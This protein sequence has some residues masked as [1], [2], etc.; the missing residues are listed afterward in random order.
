MTRDRLASGKTIFDP[1]TYGLIVRKRRKREKRKQ[2]FLQRFGI[3][4]QLIHDTEYGRGR[5]VPL[6]RFVVMNI[7][8]F[9]EPFPPEVVK[10][11]MPIPACVKIGGGDKWQLTELL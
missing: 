7:A 6:E 8:L 3:S 4:K 1:K 5:T 2:Y 10:A 9:G 11:C